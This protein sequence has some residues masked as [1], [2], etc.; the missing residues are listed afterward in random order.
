VFRAAQSVVI[1]QRAGRDPAFMLGEASL[2]DLDKG[3][4]AFVWAAASGNIDKFRMVNPRSRSAPNPLTN[5]EGAAIATGLLLNQY[6]K[7]FSD[8]EQA[9]AALWV[10]ADTVEFAIQERGDQW[11]AVMPD[12]ALEF[13]RRIAD[14][15]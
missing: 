5:R 12:D 9:L 3:S 10:G 6:R 1:E 7:Q 11:R 4:Y 13:V 2:G 15:L 14:R 8:P